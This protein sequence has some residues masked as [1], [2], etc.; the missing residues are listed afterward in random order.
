MQETNFKNWL[1]GMNLH[2]NP[3]LLYNLYKVLSEK[4]AN[5]HFNIIIHDQSLI[6]KDNTRNNELLL[7]KAYIA[8]FIHY[9]RE[10]YC[11]GQNIEEWF[12]AKTASL[13]REILAKKTETPDRGYKKAEYYINP[14]ERAYFVIMLIITIFFFAVLG[15]SAIMLKT[16]WSSTIFAFL[17]TYILL[18]SL[19][20]LLKKGFLIGFLRGSAVKVS[21]KQFPYIYQLTNQIASKLQLTAPE[22]YIIE[23]GGL[24]NAFATR[25]MG[26]NFI[27]LYSDIVEAGA[28]KGNK[29]LP[30]IIGHELAHI[31]RHH[32]LKKTLLF[33]AYLVPF[34]GL[35]YS[36]ACEYTCDKIGFAVSSPEAAQH[37]LLLLAGGKSLYNQIDVNEY[38]KSYRLEA[39]FWTWFTEKFLSHPH[40]TKRIDKLFIS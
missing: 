2:N 40:L 24:L 6:I 26:N 3:T 5:E 25:F 4:T 16:E 23:S 27:I 1:F 37:G 38:I 17:I 22:T 36:R 33:P 29:S 35:A 39:G 19:L 15:F 13:N 9:L 10:N 8:D 32:M 18:F 11:M 20:L 12:R 34:L 31:K 30:F 14:K 21:E 7:D 28:S